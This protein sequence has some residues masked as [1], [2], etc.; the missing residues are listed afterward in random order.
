MRSRRSA[1][2]THASAAGAGR[3]TQ[4]SWRFPTGLGGNSG[5]AGSEAVGR[6]LTGWQVVKRLLPRCSPNTSHT[7]IGGAAIP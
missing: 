6:L 7:L 4:A 5:G 1:T 3:L 2:M